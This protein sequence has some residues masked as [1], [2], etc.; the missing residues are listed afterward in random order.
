MTQYLPYT[1]KEYMALLHRELKEYEAELDDLTAEERED[2]H[3]W[4]ADG[5]SPYNNG[6]Y[7]C[8]EYG[9]PMD[10]IAAERVIEDMRLN[11]ES[12]GISLE[13]E[14]CDDVSDDDIP[15]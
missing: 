14:I 6:W 12:Y 4:V 10:Y 8:C 3:K 1:K 2:L 5:N 9:H 13:R 15:F 11:P 7:I